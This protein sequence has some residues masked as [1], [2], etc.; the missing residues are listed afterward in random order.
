[1]F[2]L[3]VDQDLFLLL[4]YGKDGLVGCVWDAGHLMARVLDGQIFAGQTK[5]FF[6]VVEVEHIALVSLVCLAPAAKHHDLLLVGLNARNS[7][8]LNEKIWL[9]LN[10]FPIR[11]LT[12]RGEYV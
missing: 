9:T 7:C 3:S 2:G 4:I 8:S 11:A 1:M 5:L 6:N 12:E 10:W